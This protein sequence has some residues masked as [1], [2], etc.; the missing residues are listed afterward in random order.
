MF[1]MESTPYQ[2]YS[3]SFILFMESALYNS[4]THYLLYFF[5][6]YAIS[7]PYHYFHNFDN[8]LYSISLSFIFSTGGKSAFFQSAL[9]VE[10]IKDNDD[11]M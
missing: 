8:Q 7:I 4:K 11:Y 10:N 1:F 6:M 3:I 5:R 2:L 9:S